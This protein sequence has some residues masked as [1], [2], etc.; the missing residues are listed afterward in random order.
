MTMILEANPS[1]ERRGKAV[2]HVFVLKKSIDV[3]SKETN[4]NEEYHPKEGKRVENTRNTSMTDVRT[5]SEK[6]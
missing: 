4:Q 2:N 6:Q 3:H 1:D 5:E